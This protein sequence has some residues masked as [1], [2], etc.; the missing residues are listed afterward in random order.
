LNIHISKDTKTV[1]FDCAEIDSLIHLNGP[2]GNV[3]LSAIKRR[4]AIMPAIERYLA[5]SGRGTF[6]RRQ[7]LQSLQEC[8]KSPRFFEINNIDQLAQF[9][10]DLRV[11]D[12]NKVPWY[13]GLLQ[14]FWHLNRDKEDYQIPPCTRIDK[15]AVLISVFN[16]CT[17]T[18][19]CLKALRKYSSL[20]AHV[21]IINNSTDDISA[22]KRLVVE[23]KLADVWIDS[24]CH[25]HSEGL[26]RA[27]PYVRDFRYL[28]TLDNDAIALRP[29][30][31]EEMLQI[32]KDRNA[33][34]AGPRTFPRSHSIKGVAIHPCCMV[35]DQLALASKF[36]IDFFNQW[37][38]DVGHMLT[39]D[40]VAHS[41]T[42]VCVSHDIT[43]DYARGSSLINKSVRHFWYS[44]RILKLSD[45]E[46][47]DGVR[48]GL[49]R[50]KLQE[51]LRSQEIKAIVT[52]ETN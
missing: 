36:Q 18:E 19:V 37:P 41:I 32:L 40:C 47:L 42:I 7:F 12:L 46:M 20:I 5:E 48:V 27:L 11:D 44:S 2:V 28:C 52:K 14:S 22:F 16:E 31:L 33:G 49:I 24:G 17:F 25:T 4:K 29:G 21:V 9:Y 39:W 26:N 45:N 43:K 35:I 10:Q 50:A 1:R 38:W 15:V 30:W 51:G 13:V 6:Y 8:L 34:I 3:I 23:R